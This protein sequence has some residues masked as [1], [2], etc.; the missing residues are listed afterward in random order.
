MYYVLYYSPPISSVLA[1]GS[2]NNI[3]HIIIKVN[4]LV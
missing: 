1:A 4:K 3:F 2:E